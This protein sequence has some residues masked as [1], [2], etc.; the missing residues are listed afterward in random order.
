MGSETPRAAVLSPDPSG[1]HTDL[2]YACESAVLMDFIVC[3]ESE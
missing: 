1:L 3:K 2:S